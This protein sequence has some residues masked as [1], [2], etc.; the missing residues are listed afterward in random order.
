MRAVVVSDPG[1]AE[2][3]ETAP[4]R[5]RPGEVRV[6][7]ATAA[8]CATDRRLAARGADPPR[9][10]GHEAAG[11]L[12]DG[13]AVGIHPDV[14]CG[15]CRDCLAGLENRCPDKTSVGLDRDGGLAEWLT[16]PAAHAIPLAGLD[17]GIAPMLEPLACCLHA[18]SGLG[19]RRGEAALVVG[20]GSMGLLSMWA[21]QAAGATVAVAQR[22]PERR[23]LAARLGA[24]V[25][26]APDQDPAAQL[27][28]AP[29]V[30]V[31][32]APG[33]EPLAWALGKVAVGGRVHAFASTTGGAPVDA[34]VL[35][36]RHLTLV[37]STGSSL[38]DYR[39]A[40]DLAASAKVPLDRLPRCT[41]PLE[42]V[43]EALLGRD[44]HHALKVTVD[45]GGT[46]R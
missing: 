4:P 10:P 20:A 18:L 21:L 43:L 32:A 5:P 30:A 38:G 34:N 3:V 15:R 17:L 23:R 33:A 2:L 31:V 28:G 6:R 8:L 37:G 39:R 46:S 25:A 9:V 13:T 11:R 29:S 40:R 14:G 36:Y 7:V 19:V 12:D 41:I 26:L 16:I 44:R 27:G 1:T 24:D 35:H 45:V 22:S 42:R